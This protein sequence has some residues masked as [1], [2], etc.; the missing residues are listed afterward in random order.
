ME[1]IHRKLEPLLGRYLKSFPVIGITGPRQS[2][3]STL[4]KTLLKDNYEYITF[5]DLSLKQFFNDDPKGFINRYNQKVIFDEIQY[6]PDLFHYVKLVVDENRLDYGRFVL[7]GSSHFTLN[8]H[9]SESLAGRIGL[10]NLLPFQYSELPENNNNLAML[11]GSYPELVIRDYRDSD[12]WFN[13]YINTYLQK[14]LRVLLNIQEIG[15]FTRFIKLLAAQI[16][17]VLN[18]SEISRDLGISVTTLK[19]WVSVLEASF[20]IFLLPPYFKN[21]HK[22]IVKSP[23]IY[24]YDTGL[25]SFLTGIETQKQFEN[26]IMAGNLF[27]NY[28]IS[29]IVKK[30]AH[31]GKNASLFFYRSGSGVEVD[32]ISE[33]AGRRDLIEIKS[34]SDFKK[35]YLKNAENI[36]EANDHKYVLYK[37]ENIELSDN[38]S[39]LNYQDYLRS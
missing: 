10:L 28:V 9:I 22:R 5:D 16:G 25:A 26:G 1:Y 13:S 38:A 33:I 3:K 17:N 39:F 18:L 2:G 7:T 19:R 30:N 37:G 27:E 14:D 6:V 32:L 31:E 34:N 36:F 35:V 8:K 11:K 29:E 21:Y 20:I 24:F 12:I 23:K 4:V 15:D